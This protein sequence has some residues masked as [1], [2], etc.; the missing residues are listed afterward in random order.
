MVIKTKKVN[1]PKF[2]FLRKL[3]EKNWKADRQAWKAKWKERLTKWKP[4]AIIIAWYT[5][6][7]YMFVGFLFNDYSW[8]ALLFAFALY[9]VYEKLRDDY[10]EVKEIAKL[11]EEENNK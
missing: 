2:K 4:F 10:I 3:K 6:L 8:K 5:V 11:N 1:L 7:F 9:F